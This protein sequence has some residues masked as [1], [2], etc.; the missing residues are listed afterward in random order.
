M[1]KL[2]VLSI[3]LAIIL[4]FSILQIDIINAQDKEQPTVSTVF[5]ET[6]I[7]EALN[8]LSMQTGINI[9]YDRTVTGTVTLDLKD[10]PLEKALEM[11]CISGGYAYKKVDVYYVVGLPDPS[12]STFQHLTKT[13]TIDLNYIT[14]SEATSLLPTYYGQF[15]ESS[16]ERE[17][18][19]TITAPEGVIEKFKEDLAKIDIPKKQVLI[20]VVVTEVSTEVLEERGTSFVD[21][22]S[23]SGIDDQNYYD[24]LNESDDEGYFVGLNDVLTLAADTSYGKLLTELRALEKKEKADIKAN[25]KIR[26]TDGESAELFVGEERSIILRTAEDESSMESVDVGV[27]LEI[28]P[29]ILNQDELQV[30]VSPDISHF[31]HESEEQLVVRRSEL[32]TSVYAKEGETLNLAGMTLD[33]VIS[34]ENQVPLLG[35]IP[36]LRWLFRSKSVEKGERELLIFLT[37]EI[38]KGGENATE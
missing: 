38:V 6:D 28:T 5:F 3:C 30:D 20:K 17:G 25:P 14:A 29:K 32:N 36:L 4:A 21:L 37:P 34:Y 22:F 7:R 26:V 12:S 33:E 11:M 9:I 13:E 24:Y 15:V 27:S 8:E 2:K 10:V 35:D 19:I 23:G 16:S 31:T 1:K 18:M